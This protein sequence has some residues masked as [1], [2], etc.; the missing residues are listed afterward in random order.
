[1]GA[2]HRNRPVSICSVHPPV[3][4]KSRHHHC[5]NYRFRSLHRIIR[6]NCGIV[7]GAED[8]YHSQKSPFFLTGNLQLALHGELT[9]SIMPASSSAGRC[10]FCHSASF[11]V[12]SFGFDRTGQHFT[13]G[14]RCSIRSVAGNFLTSLQNRSLQVNN[15]LLAS[16][17]SASVKWFP[18]SI[19]FPS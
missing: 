13:V 7:D 9:Q 15:N 2:I 17:R 1:M 8:V 5:V 10:F 3:A 18:I 19:S 12:Y 16:D 4:V 11:W 14:I 6:F